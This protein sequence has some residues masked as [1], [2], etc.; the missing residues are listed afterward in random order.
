M[1][2][3]L[4]LGGTQFFGKK[5]VELMLGKEWRVT[6]ATRGNKAHPFGDKVDHIL[7]DARNVDHEGWQDIQQLKSA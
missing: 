1:K 2:K 7:L 3:V 5:A 4:V 6:I